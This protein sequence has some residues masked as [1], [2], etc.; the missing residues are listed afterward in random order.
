MITIAI[1]VATLII[2][3]NVILRNFGASTSW[4]EELVRYLFIL[5]TFIGSSVCVRKGAHLGVDV[6]PEML[7]ERYRKW[8]MIFV[9]VIALGFVC[10]L[11]WLSVLIVEFSFSTGQVSP[12]LQLPIFLIY[13]V[14]LTGSVLMVVRYVQ[15]IYLLYRGRSSVSTKEFIS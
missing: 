14:I 9:N 4:A 7:P 8:L 3:F 2:F 5:I 12:A 15:A 10:I 1:F 11:T 13:S 6:L